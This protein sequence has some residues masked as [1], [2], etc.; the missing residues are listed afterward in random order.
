MIR[1]LVVP[2]FRDGIIVAVLG[3]GN[4]P[5]EYDQNDIDLI[6]SFADLAWDI[7]ERKRNEIKY[8]IVA[9]FTY[10]WETWISQNGTYIY[11]SPSCARITEYPPEK[12][13]NNPDFLLSIT[14]P[15]DY[16][17]V[18][19]YFSIVDANLQ[20]EEKLVFRII[21]QSGK[22][23][24]IEHICVPIFTDDGTYLGRRGSNR[25]VTDKK[26]IEKTLLKN[27]NLLEDS[28]KIAHLGSYEIDII[29]NTVF[30]SKETLRIFGLA[31][32]DPAPTIEE[33]QAFIHPE[34]VNE[35]YQLFD[36]SEELE[37]SLN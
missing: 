31:E 3:V 25:D 27:R 26:S 2:V 37:K 29:Q 11:C 7:A 28:Q 30:W 36:E 1:E 16:E 6:S 23:R 13:I 34:D 20:Q 4:K 15:E 5:A 18:K 33:Y 12:F 35:L 24:Y 14:H 19:H 22:E 8:Q 10:D 32:N 17:N 9:D 21:N